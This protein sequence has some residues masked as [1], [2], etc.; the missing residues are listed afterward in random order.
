[1]DLNVFVFCEILFHRGDG[2]ASREDLLRGVVNEFVQRHEYL[3][4][5]FALGHDFLP[6]SFDDL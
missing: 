3:F 4:F 6:I 5:L 1:M 2:H